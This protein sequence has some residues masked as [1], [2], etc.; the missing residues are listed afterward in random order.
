[1][2]RRL[3]KLRWPGVFKEQ[4]RFYQFH[5]RDERAARYRHQIDA[6]I[7]MRRQGMQH[8]MRQCNLLV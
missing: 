2:G 7:K 1:M 3:R 5:F 6:G 8:L 4:G